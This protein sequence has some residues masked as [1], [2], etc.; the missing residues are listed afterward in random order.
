MENIRISNVCD[1]ASS[2][3]IK[4]YKDIFWEAPWNEW[5]ICKSCWLFYPKKFM[6][7]CTCSNSEL[8]PFYKNKELKETFNALIEKDWYSELVAQI[9][10]EDIWFIWWWN[11]SISNINEDKLWL[12]KKQLYDLSKWILEK[13]NDFNLEQFYYFAEIGVKNNYRWNDIA[14]ELYRK[15][16]E[17]LKEK[18]E[19][20]ILVRTTRLSDVPYKWFI[21]E[22]YMEVFEYNDDQD[23]VILV[24]KI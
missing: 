20:F 23:R 9:L 17:N 4:M 24:Y 1:N 8:E 5:F 15:N 13:F 12:E 18:W 19:K 7:K 3:K 11:S 22:W 2:K 21:K 14:W 10:E 16:L 6:W